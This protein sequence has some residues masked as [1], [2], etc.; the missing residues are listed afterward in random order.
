MSKLAT[1]RISYRV[2]H[3]YDIEVEASSADNAEAWAQTLLSRTRSALTGSRAIASDI[4]ICDVAMAGS[5]LKLPV[6]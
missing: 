6:F 1:Y 3:V 5:L 4:R 2:S